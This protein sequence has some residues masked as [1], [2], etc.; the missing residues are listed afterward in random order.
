MRA[1]IKRITGQSLIGKA[2]SNHWVSMDTSTAG[3]GN[4]AGASP[5][6]LVLL[7]LGG[8]LSMDVLS[9]LAKKRVTIQDY[10]VQAEAERAEEHPRIFTRI[11]L[12]LILYGENIPAEAVDRAIALSEEKYCSVAAMLRK[13]A[14]VTIAFEIR[15]GKEPLD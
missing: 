12:R 1:V 7:A 13:S 11:H 8:C 2:D 14:E 6:E 3:G 10:E 5:M 15:P 9:I 4:D